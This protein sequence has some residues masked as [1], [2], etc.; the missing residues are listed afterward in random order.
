MNIVST[1]PLDCEHVAAQIWDW[2]DHELDAVRWAAIESH[3]A[4]CTGC[5]EH[6]A[7]ARGFLHQVKQPTAPSDL[8]ALRTRIRSAL[9]AGST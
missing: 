8:S 1:Q 5:S 9:A 4:T 2:L 3:L 7:F 6:V